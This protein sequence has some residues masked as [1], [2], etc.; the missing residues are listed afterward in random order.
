MTRI[1]YFDIE[2]S[3][4]LVWTHYIGS[5]VS[6]N[7]CQIEQHKRIICI[8]YNFSD[9]PIDKVRR[10]T[11]DQK[12]QDD[13]KMLLKFNEIARKADLLKGHNAQSFDVK[14]IR[15]AIALRGLAEA[16]CETPCLDTLKEYRRTFRFTSNRLD[17]IARHLGIGCKNR[18][19]YQLWIDV[20]NGDR[21]ALK[22]MGQYCDQDVKLL[23][24]VDE[25]LYPYVK[26]TANE[27]NLMYNVVIDDIPPV[28]SNENCNNDR[29]ELFIKD[30]NKTIKGRLYKR[31][32]CKLC[33]SRVTPRR[34]D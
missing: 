16:W 28:C 32:M 34:D 7:P 3:P 26:P 1:L 30:G 12:T 8:S 27:Y 22:E 21:K 6:I 13:T 19:D 10:L 18:T 11:W 14:E 25:R 23:R 5:K 15:S 31:Y 24:Q 17:A 33:G 4:M 9:E 29:R 2:T 20:V